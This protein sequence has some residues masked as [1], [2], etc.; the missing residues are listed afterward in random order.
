MV[1]QHILETTRQHFLEWLEYVAGRYNAKVDLEHY[2]TS[3]YIFKNFWLGFFLFT[4]EPEENPY[5]VVGIVK[6]WIKPVSENRLLV[7]LQY[8]LDD[9]IREDATERFLR[10]RTEI[11]TLFTG[12]S[13]ERNVTNMNLSEQQMAILQSI[14]ELAGPN[15]FTS[16][17]AVADKTGLATRTVLRHLEAFESVGYVSLT[18]ELGGEDN[19]IIRLEGLGQM[20]LLNPQYGRQVTEKSSI[21]FFGTANIAMLNAGQMANVESINQNIGALAESGNEQFA[22]AIKQITEAVVALQDEIDSAE[23]TEILEILESVSTQAAL[24]SEQRQKGVVKALLTGLASALTA[25]GSLAEIWS[26]WGAGIK[27]FFGL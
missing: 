23:R 14:E 12:H 10:L 18:H 3:L 22:E 1:E 2:E 4:S 16:C 8:V 13:Y 21:N 19:C 27:T 11:K 20:V 5:R 7:E 24:P 6:F 15:I 26:T 17:Q 9:P 25:T